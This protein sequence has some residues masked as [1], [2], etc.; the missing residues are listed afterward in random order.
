MTHEGSQGVHNLVEAV[1]ISQISR[2][3]S[4]QPSQNGCQPATNV[5]GCVQL[6]TKWLPWVPVIK[7]WEVS[8]QEL[9]SDG[10]SRFCWLLLLVASYTARVKFSSTFD[11]NKILGHVVGL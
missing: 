7:H 6:I 11:T 2:M 10:D 8:S 4:G 9:S 1:S 3:L 5:C